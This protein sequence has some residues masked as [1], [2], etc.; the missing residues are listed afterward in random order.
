MNFLALFVVGVGAALYRQSFDVGAVANGTQNATLSD[1][2]FISGSAVAASGQLVLTRAAPGL[3]GSLVVPALN[4]SALGWTASFVVRFGVLAAPVNTTPTA[5]ALRMHWGPLSLNG[6]DAATVGS[7]VIKTTGVVASGALRADA[8]I[9]TPV[10]ILSGVVINRSETAN[11][12]VFAAW[13][14][15]N[16]ASFRTAGFLTDVDL[17]DVEIPAALFVAQSVDSFVW[18]I[19]SISNPSFLQDVVI[20]DVVVEAPCGE[21]RAQGRECVW[22]SGG[23]F[24]CRLASV[25]STA[26]QALRVSQTVGHSFVT[27]ALGMDFTVYS[28]IDVSAVGLLDADARGING[29]LV[30]RIFD[31]ATDRVVVGPVTVKAGEARADD[32]N[33]FV[34]KV[35]PTV[36]LQPGVY[37]IVSVGFT[38]DRYLS[39]AANAGSVV[40]AD[41]G[42]GTVLITGSVSGGN[43]T[44]ASAANIT[45]TARVCGATFR[46]AVVPAP[47]P[48]PLPA[49]EFA[50]CEVVACAGLATGEHNVR[51]ALRFCDNDMAGGGWLRLWRANETRC[52]ANG[53]TSARNA[54]ASGADPVGCRLT[55]PSCAAVQ[56]THA[57]FDF[58]EVRGGNWRVWAFGAPDGFA[59]AAPPGDG[60][61]VRDGNGSVVWTLAVGLTGASTALLCPCEGAFQN[62][63]ATVTSLS[64]VGPNWTCDRAPVRRMLWTA[65]FDGQS[66]LTCSGAPASSGAPLWFQ[67]TLATP[68]RTLSVAICKDT[69]ADED[70]KLSLGDLYVRA[71]VGFDKARTC[72]TTTIAATT[73]AAAT[74]AAATT[75]TTTAIAVTTATTT[76]TTSFTTSAPSTTTS[77]PFTTLASVTTTSIEETTIAVAADST[78][79]PLIAGVVAGAVVLL[80]LVGVAVAVGMRRRRNSAPSNEVPM[81]T[82]SASVAPL[83][84]DEPLR[85]SEY[86]PISASAPRGEYASMRADS[87]YAKSVVDFRIKS[88][89]PDYG[90][91]TPAEIGRE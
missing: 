65:L 71:T 21:C 9:R 57:P 3:N 55:S 26:L 68:Q 74:E 37:S 76:T 61:V 48:P 44:L 20:D 72:P 77:A 42:N 90:A 53:W 51:G 18:A 6:S 25:A 83:A 46:F 7:W 89:T 66:T 23:Q 27:T 63:T 47:P 19:T 17:R 73:S 50:D 70:F 22:G 41:T 1:G 11:A 30:A 88:T 35:V 45:S 38:S 78:D 69:D 8:V 5:D 2:A 24:E 64:A 28:A 12:T 43:G 29:T 16:G 62:S 81:A 86:G 15:E 33:P 58:G 60:I 49:R 91:L 34:F 13:D 79:V 36:R 82:T 75:A 14:P 59:A 80:A 39:S 84:K 56:E 32:A 52:E 67:R 85:T 54:R 40:A 4:G 10:A 87:H 31:R